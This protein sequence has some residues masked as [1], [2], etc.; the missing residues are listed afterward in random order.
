M[1]TPKHR[2]F[3]SDTMT[4]P[5]EAM[6]QAM[7]SAEVGDDVC[8]EDPTVQ[9]LEAQ[10]AQILGKEAALFVAS[11]VMG[12][13]CAL[14]V[15]G[16]PGE[17]VILPE[18]CHVVEHENATVASLWGLVTRTVTP[19]RATYLL[20]E[21]IEP[22]LRRGDDLHEPRT[23]LIVLENALSDGTVMPVEPMRQI[24]ALADDFGV[25]I[26]LDGA[27]LF[28][29][30]LSL[31]VEPVEIA[32]QVDSVMICLSKGLGAPVGSL[33]AGDERFV[34]AARRRRKMLGGG[35]RQVGV[36]AAPAILAL[37]DGRARL[38]TDHENAR[39]LA[40]GLSSLKGV[41]LDLASVQTNMVW[42]RIDRPGKSCDDLVH[43][44][45][46][47]GIHT[48][49]P[50]HRAVRFVTSSQVEAEDIAVLIEAVADYL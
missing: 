25:K 35:M 3:R 16:K 40:R 24:R 27:R 18:A 8:N 5:T 38:A 37:T 4:L 29:A 43:F 13:Q 36:L 39:L 50:M 28:N 34:E 7:A 6:R 17:E 14:G 32:S 26:H 9:R 22:R 2:E 31:G 47:R 10:G 19:T 44:L 23:G 49:P 1:T 15:H 20:P 42:I 45:A 41:V 11:G 21:D 12:N 33:L 30:A 46:Q 48:Y